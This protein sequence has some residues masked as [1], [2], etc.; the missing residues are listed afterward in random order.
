MSINKDN[1]TELANQTRRYYF[2]HN[3]VVEIKGI[4]ELIVSSSGSH[5][6]RTNDK[7]LHIIP[8]GWLHIE[9]D[10]ENWTV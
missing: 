10:A 1:I 6:L 2:P 5:R 7:K 4:F 8:T 3:E 9:I